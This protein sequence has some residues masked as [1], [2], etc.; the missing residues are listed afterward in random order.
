MNFQPPLLGLD[1]AP[2]VAMKAG[3]QR[4][5]Q[6]AQCGLVAV[7]SDLAPRGD[8]G[9]PRLR[10]RRM[11]EAD[12][13]CGWSTEPRNIHRRSH[14]MNEERTVDTINERVREVAAHLP[15]PV[16]LD[17]DMGGTTR[18]RGHER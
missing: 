12:S 7:Q 9:V 6:C 16:E 14:T 8:G 1:L 10:P 15:F 2:T 17:A 3:R 11:V 4:V 5:W 13:S 18:D